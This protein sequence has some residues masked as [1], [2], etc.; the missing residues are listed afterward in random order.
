MISEEEADQFLQIGNSRRELNIFDN[1]GRWLDKTFSD[2]AD[3]SNVADIEARKDPDATRSIQ[4][5]VEARDL[6]F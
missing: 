1:V 2:K 3:D 6:T 5:I 4:E